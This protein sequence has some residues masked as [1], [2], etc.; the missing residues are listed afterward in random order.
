MYIRTHLLRN[1]KDEW[2]ITLFTDDGVK[3]QASIVKNYKQAL[4]ESRKLSEEN[5]N[6]EYIVGNISYN[7]NKI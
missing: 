1:N 4:K 6:C 5:G 7:G 2:V 3:V